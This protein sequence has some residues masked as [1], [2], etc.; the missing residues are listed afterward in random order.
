[1]VTEGQI[2]KPLPAG[3][4]LAISAGALIAATLIVFGAVLPAEFNLDPLG[5]GRMSGLNRLWAPA[6]VVFDTSKSEA[7]L[8]REYAA[9]FRAD[10]IEIPLR[11]GGDPTRGDELE[12]K[13]QMKKDAT[14]IYEWSVADIPKPD[15]FY[16][17]FHGHTLAAGKDMTVATYKQATGT[18]ANGALAAPFDG[19]HGWFFQ[20]QSERAVVVHL[21]ISGFYDL[22]PPGDIGNEAGIIANVPADKAFG[23]Q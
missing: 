10:V 9:G 17:D 20:N 21:K 15:E 1:V 7:P 12:Y 3:R 16:F 18:S 2:S 4:M 6:E 11:A 22:I 14:F 19:V 23:E 8:A 5:L 13:V